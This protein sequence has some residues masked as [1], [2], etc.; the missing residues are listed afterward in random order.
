MIKVYKK[1]IAFLTAVLSLPV[2]ASCGNPDGQTNTAA[3]IT[4]AAETSSVSET[5]SG[6]VEVISASA[7]EITDSMRSLKF[8]K[9]DITEDSS[10]EEIIRAGKIA[11][12]FFG[13]NTERFFG[14]GA[15]PCGIAGGWK[16][17]GTEDGSPFADTD[18][19]NYQKIEGFFIEE[20]R[21]VAMNYKAAVS[22]LMKALYLTEKGF[23]DLCGSSAVTYK[24]IDGSL[25]I[26]ETEI[27]AAEYGYAEVVDYTQ[28]GD[29]SITFNCRLVGENDNAV[30]FT[31]T[32]KKNNYWRLDGCSDG[33]A[34]FLMKDIDLA[35]KINVDENDETVIRG[36]E[37]AESYAEMSWNYL[38]GAAW[39]DYVNIKYFDFDDKSEDNYFEKDGIP[40]YKLLITDYSYDELMEYIKSFCTDE[41]FD[42]ISDIYFNSIIAE[43]DNCIFVNGNEP[44]FLYTMRNERA[45]IIGYTENADGTVT[46]DCY[47]K[48]TEETDNDLYFSFTL[49]EENKLCGEFTV[50]TDMEICLFSTDWY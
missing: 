3:E 5:E 39:D 26:S 17:A 23:E 9:I 35:P 25:Y 20:N 18:G 41:V 36:R 40:F 2:F 15:S 50:S 4:T 7:E 28:D 12:K 16:T 19:K 31:F 48:T 44:T 32:L 42:E 8:P 11:G 34:L 13:G 30:P 33:Y 29:D 21:Y 14:G 6:A 49:N 37:F 24:E 1:I 47:A 45:Q 10:P 38:N 46:Y 27:G 43:K 22:Y